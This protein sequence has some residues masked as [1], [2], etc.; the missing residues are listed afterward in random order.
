MDAHAQVGHVPSVSSSPAYMN[1]P[2]LVALSCF[3]LIEKAR[4]NTP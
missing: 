4:L 3:G 1:V 2:M